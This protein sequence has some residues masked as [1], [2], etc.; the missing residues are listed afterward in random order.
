MLEQMAAEESSEFVFCNPDTGLPYTDIKRAFTTARLKAGIVDFHFHDLRHTTAT[1]LGDA[2]VDAIKLAAIMG[3][4]D[5][6]VAM[7][8]THPRALGLR[9]AMENLAG[10]KRVPALFPTNNQ[11]RPLPIAA[12]G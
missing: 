10:P 4:S 12:S 5:V 1:R 8:Y 11:R 3:W 2:G 7:R 9:D 6:R